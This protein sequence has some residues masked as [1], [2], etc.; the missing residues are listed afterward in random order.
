MRYRLGAIAVVVGVVVATVGMQAATA[1]GPTLTRLQLDLSGTSDWMM[2][3][4]S[5]A[6]VTAHYVNTQTSGTTVE[7]GYNNLLLKG[8]TNSAKATSVR[9]TP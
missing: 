9:F 3:S 1:G 6:V 2:L 7:R 5:D 4:V 8:A